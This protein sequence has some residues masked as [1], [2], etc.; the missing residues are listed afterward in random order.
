MT[1]KEKKEIIDYLSG[2]RD[3]E[4]G[5]ALYARHGLNLRLKKQFALDKTEATREIMINELKNLAGLS[6]A[7]FAR[8]PRRAKTPNQQEEALEV[9]EVSK[10]EKPSYQEAPESI[11]KAVRFREKYKFLQDPECPDELKILVADMFTALARYKEAHAAIQ[12]AGDN[13]EPAAVAAECQ[14]AVESYIENRAIWDELDYYK[15]HGQILG[16]HP[17]FHK[18]E[19]EAAEDLSAMSDVDLMSRLRSAGVQ[20]SKQRAK[21]AASK[22]KKKK[23]ERAETALAYWTA[24]KEELREELERRKK[25]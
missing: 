6:D 19:D 5:A 22:G 10:E 2:P 3:Y 21:V 25:K 16:K 13:A 1:V 14:K 12:Q 15:E 11:K 9:P 17:I 18:K 20:E 23:N 8:L 4:E 24:R 7:E